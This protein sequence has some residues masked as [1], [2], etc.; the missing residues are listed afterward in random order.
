MPFF[1]VRLSG[2]R[3][4]EAVNYKNFNLYLAE[5]KTLHTGLPFEFNGIIKQKGS[6]LLL[7]ELV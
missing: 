3:P 2:E 7:T 5:S 6:R 1:C 4:S